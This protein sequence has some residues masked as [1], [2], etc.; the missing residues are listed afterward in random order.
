VYP[1]FN[2]NELVGWTDTVAPYRD[3]LLVLQL[4][5]AEDLAQIRSR[6]N[7]VKEIIERLEVEVIDVHS[8]GIPSLERMLSLVQLGDFV[9]YYLAVLNRVDP[10]PVT[11]IEELKQR[12][13]KRTA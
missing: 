4:R 8:K 11:A 13:A 1:E 7:A 5:D 10:T 3:K 2:H 9:S 6:M 12:L